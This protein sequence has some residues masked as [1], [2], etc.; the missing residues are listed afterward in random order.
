MI[1][2]MVA[3][4]ALMYFYDDPSAE[5]RAEEDPGDAGAMEVGDAV[6]TTSGFY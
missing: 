1:L 5:E 2:M 6:M 4:F 3:M